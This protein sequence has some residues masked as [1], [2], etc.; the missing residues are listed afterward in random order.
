MKTQHTLLTGADRLVLR[1]FKCVDAR[2]YTADIKNITSR[3]NQTVLQAVIKIHKL[4]LNTYHNAALDIN[5]IIQ[6]I[7]KQ[8]SKTTYAA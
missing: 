1:N 7:K 4:A 3:C 5:L 8:T 6:N 2:S